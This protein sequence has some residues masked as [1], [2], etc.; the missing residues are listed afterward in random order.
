M[1]VQGVQRDP[2]RQSFPAASA[3]ADGRLR[4]PVGE[5]PIQSTHW[6]DGLI[7]AEMTMPLALQRHFIDTFDGIVGHRT[8]ELWSGIDVESSNLDDSPMRPGRE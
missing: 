3:S 6:D 1:L 8:A 2:P 5:M 7:G 4:G